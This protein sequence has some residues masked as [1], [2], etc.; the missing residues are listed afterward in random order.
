MFSILHL[1]SISLLKF[2]PLENGLSWYALIFLIFLTLFFLG[3]IYCGSVCPFG[4]LQEI[5]YKIARKLNI[6]LI[7]PTKNVDKKARC[8]K[9]V[10]LLSGLLLSVLLQNSAIISFEVFILF[11]TAHTSF[12]GWTLVAIILLISIFSYRFWCKY[13]CP[14]GAFNG[15]CSKLS[16]FKIHANEQNCSHCSICQNIC[17][18]Q[19]IDEQLT[20]DASECILCGKCVKNCPQNCFKLQIKTHEKL[21]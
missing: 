13:L 20:I 8:L 17:P 3:N 12:L 15:V 16:L 19:A 7:N 4:A 14:I 11:F 2:P 21:R 9:Y 18:T 1:S 10:I 6:P 5:L